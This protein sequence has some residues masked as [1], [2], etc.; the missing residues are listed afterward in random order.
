MRTRRTLGGGIYARQWMAVYSEALK[1]GLCD[2]SE[3][4]SSFSNG[5]PDDVLSTIK[6]V[7]SYMST[8]LDAL[9]NAKCPDSSIAESVATIQSILRRRGDESVDTEYPV[10]LVLD[11]KTRHVSKRVWSCVV[12]TLRAAGV[13]VVGLAS[14]TV[15]EIRGISKFCS[16]P[17][18]EVIFFHSAGELQLAC[19]EGKIRYGD[20][21]FF[22]CG[23]L[24]WE[25][26]P[27]IGAVAGTVCSLGFDPERI[28]RN[29][30]VLPFG[31]TRKMH[32]ADQVT[33][34]PPV[35]T[36][37]PSMTLS[38]AWSEGSTIELYKECYGLSIGLYSQEFAID[39]AAVNLIVELVNDNPHVYDLGFSWGGV[40]G[41]TIKGIQPGRFTST[42]GFWNQ[43]YAGVL[44]DS[45]RYPPPT[46][47]SPSM[48][49]IATPPDPD[50]PTDSNKAQHVD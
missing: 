31:R 39:E 10:G 25:G 33:S 46:T 23:S 38:S 47:T 7:D 21:V 3:I 35:L 28:K 18:M 26:P 42:D 29:Y 43:R 44:W 16:E 24:L 17:L 50:T 41:L 32:E 27:D 20:K 30:R 22:N 34:S 2:D 14:F 36:R 4:M 13:R 40:N 8:S 12:D 45:S 15:D 6:S 9:A 1:L 37:S 48:S 11:I 5:D 49:S 19:H